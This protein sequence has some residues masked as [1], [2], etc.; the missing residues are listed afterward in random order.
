LALKD[1]LA[2]KEDQPAHWKELS[3]EIS[4]EEA[5]ERKRLWYV[6]STRVKRRLIL[7]PFPL[8]ESIGKK[9]KKAPVAAL[10]RVLGLDGVLAG[11][12]RYP[13]HGGGEWT[14]TVR[15]ADP[16]W[17]PAEPAQLAVELIPQE[18]IARLP[19]LLPPLSVGA[20]RALHSATEALL[21]SRCE[22]KHWFQYV[23]GLRDPEIGRRS[24][25]FGSAVAR[26]QIVHDVLEQYRLEAELDTLIDDAVRKWDADAPPPETAE[27]AGYR[28]QL[29]R[30]IQ[31]VVGDPAYREVADLP[32]AQR[33]LRFVRLAG[34]DQ[35]WQGAFDL[36]ARMNRGQVLLDVKTG[37][38]GGDLALKAAQY[39]P[40]REVYAAA[41]QVIAGEPVAE[42]RFHFSRVGK[43][44][45]HEFSEAELARLGVGLEELVKRMEGGRPRRTEYPAECGHC[46]FKRVGWCPGVGSG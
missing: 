24:A 15:I 33:E 18:A 5:A 19:G 25:D 40:Q 35:G 41:A 21:L 1:P 8:D 11:E 45:K 3:E 30:E 29:Q 38:D 26:G 37:G 14:A 27:G 36:A 10:T 2:E 13:R 39:G 34:P 17:V 12:I 44:I 7:S 42:F 32:G 31:G 4:R 16:A 6:A 43:Q 22:T 9:N 28:R 46:G 23:L 20:G